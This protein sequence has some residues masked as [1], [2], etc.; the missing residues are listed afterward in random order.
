[1]AYL[2]DTNILGRLANM[3]DPHYV[4]ADRAV[5]ELHRRGEVLHI[6]PQIMI[7]F[8][9]MATRPKTMNGL[10]LS[11]VDAEAKAA[12]F[13]AAFP[14]LVET[15]DIF[16]AWKTLVVALGVIGKQVHDARLVAVCH[17]HS[18]TH[19][20]TFNVAHFVRMAGFGPGI[21]VVDPASV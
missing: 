7:E 18:I 13:E 14:L 5:K 9:N 10:G 6:A 3:A 11:T 19:L 21:V 1:M 15:P 20:L 8:R 16:P 12:I 4:V 2:L 17:V